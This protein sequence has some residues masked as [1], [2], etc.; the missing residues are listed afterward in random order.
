MQHRL[1]APGAGGR[2]MKQAFDDSEGY[3]LKKLG[4]EFV[5]YAMTDL[6]QRSEG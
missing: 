6:V 5:H 2:P 3:E 4:E 1:T